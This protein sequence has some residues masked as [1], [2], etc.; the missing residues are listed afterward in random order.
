MPRQLSPTLQSYRSRRS[1]RHRR[2]CCNCKSRRNRRSRRCQSQQQQHTEEQRIEQKP[3]VS[4]R[5]PPPPQR[6]PPSRR[7]S[8]RRSPARAA[9]LQLHHASGGDHRLCQWRCQA[10]PLRVRGGRNHRFQLDNGRPKFILRAEGRIRVLRSTWHNFPCH[11]SSSGVST[12]RSRTHLTRCDQQ[13]ETATGIEPVS[14]DV[15]PISPS[16]KL[17]ELEATA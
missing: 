12:R 8:A 4:I 5:V 1:Y 17:S 10:Q 15:S 9:Q 6:I 11:V 7:V 13:T 2:S 16:S 3:K 14:Q